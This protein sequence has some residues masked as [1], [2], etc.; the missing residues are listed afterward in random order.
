MNPNTLFITKDLQIPLAEIQ[1][2]FARSSGPGGQ[3]VNRSE[4]QVELLWDVRNSPSLAPEQR[5]IIMAALANRIDRRG[6]LHLVSG[7]TRSQ[8]RNRQEVL[9]RFVHILQEALRPQRPRRPTRPT[10]L[11]KEKRLQRKK[12]RGQIKRWRRVDEGD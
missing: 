1:F 8:E 4:T 12:L 11:A 6:V 9:N 7:Q 10:A 5:Q 3:H 2:R